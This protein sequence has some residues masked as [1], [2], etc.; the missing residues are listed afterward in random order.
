MQGETTAAAGGRCGPCG[1]TPGGARG[2]W[3][4]RTSVGAGD[5][6]ADGGAVRP[7]LLAGPRPCGCA[8]GGVG[9]GSGRGGVYGRAGR[10]L[11]C[12]AVCARDGGGAVAAHPRAHTRRPAGR[13]RATVG[14]APG[15]AGRPPGRARGRARC[16]HRSPGTR[17]AARLPSCRRVHITGGVADRL[18]Q[19]VRIGPCVRGAASPEEDGLLRKPKRKR[20]HRRRPRH[21]CIGAD[22]LPVRQQPGAPFA[23]HRHLHRQGHSGP[24]RG[25]HVCLRQLHPADQRRVLHVRPGLA[26]APGGRL[27]RRRLEHHR[28]AGPGRLADDGADD[29]DARDRARPVPVT[30][31]ADA[32]RVRPDGVPVGPERAGRADSGVRGRLPPLVPQA[33]RG[34]A[35]GSRRLLPLGGADPAAQRDDRRDRQVR[36]MPVRVR[37]CRRAHHQDRRVRYTRLELGRAVGLPLGAR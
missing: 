23:D 33:A 8:G 4:G 1:R 29:A 15:T 30:G 3:H 11:R 14:R 31:R 7:R 32:G 35:G 28:P 37:R 16:R 17:S 18:R 2:P 10:R 12:G 6:G 19:T 5:A 21:A 26:R 36:P 20:L 22:H 24:V 34:A 25:V 9:A 27:Q 13:L